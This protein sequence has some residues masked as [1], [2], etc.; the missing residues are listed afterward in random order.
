MKAAMSLRAF[1]L[2]IS[3]ASAYVASSANLTATAMCC[4]SKWGDA[5]TCGSYPAVASDGCC[6]T[7]WST[8]CKADLDCVT[9][10]GPHPP[11]P[12]T[13][14]SPTPSR[15][16]VNVSI[17]PHDGIAA[18][19]GNVS[20]S[21]TA[22]ITYQDLDLNQF[23]QLRFWDYVYNAPTNFGGL[24]FDQKALHVTLACQQPG[25]SPAKELFQVDGRDIGECVGGSNIL[26]APYRANS[27]I[28]ITISK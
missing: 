1:I 23:Y 4:W 5:T 28:V 6:N 19:L 20:A 27:S 7:D 24:T 3:Q 25:W 26:T 11:V 16:G 15:L 14:P 18:R 17:V 8:R 9:K 10:P 12:P 21:D 13:P 22:K 2:S